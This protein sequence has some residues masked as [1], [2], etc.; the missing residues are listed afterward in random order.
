MRGN[1]DRLLR[2]P[3]FAAILA[4][5]GNSMAAM[6]SQ[7][8]QDPRRPDSYDSSAPEKPPA[9]AETG[10]SKTASPDHQ[11]VQKIQDAIKSDETLSRSAHKV[12]VTAREGK[13]TLS[14]MVASQA[15]RNAVVSKVKDMAG[16]GNLVSRL[17]ITTASQ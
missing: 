16:A 6:G 5:A 11:L 8:G 15:E 14:G 2:W 10:S 17:K 9:P 13:V 4:C 3:L 12:Q 7:S 1:A